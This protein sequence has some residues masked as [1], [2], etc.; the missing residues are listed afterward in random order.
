MGDGAALL[1]NMRYLIQDLG[2][3]LYM[4]HLYIWMR[5]AVQTVTKAA[6]RAGC[7]PTRDE[8][9]IDQGELDQR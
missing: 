2:F 1:S 3:N 4:S 5:L 8:E 6:S 7:R 9:V